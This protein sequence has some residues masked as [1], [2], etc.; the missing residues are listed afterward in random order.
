M[1][2]TEDRISRKLDRLPESPGVYLFRD[3]TGAILYIGKAR[4]L[5]QRVRSYFQAGRSEGL[6]G[7]SIRT[8]AADLDY[9]VT[10]NEVEALILESTLVKRRQPILNARLKD[11]KSFLHI[12][13]TVNE[14]FPRVLLTRRI[15][16]DGARYFGPYLPA[17]LARNLIKIINRHFQLRTCSIPIDGTLQRPCL[18][19]HIK[20]CLGPCVEGLCSPD[21]YRKAVEQVILLLEG[22]NHQ[23]LQRLHRSMH[24]AAKREQFE[25]AAFFRDRIQ[26]VQ[27]LVEKQK[28]ASTGGEN[29]DVFGYYREG[30][31]VALQLFT[32]R[33]GRVVGKREF[34]WE[35]LDWFDPPSFLRDAV[36]QYYLSARFVPDRILLP[37]PL[38]DQEI[39]EDWLTNMRENGRGRVR[40]ENPQR[41]K[42]LDLVMLVERNAVIAFESRFKLLVSEKRRLLED[43]QE[44]LQLT[45]IPRRI[46]AFDISNLQGDE[47]VASM[48]VCLDGVMSC[49]D[50]RRFRIQTVAGSNDF[51]SMQEVVGRRYRRVLNEQGTLPDLILVDGGKPQLNAALQALSQLG[52]GDLPVCALA[53]RQ[54]EIFLPDREEPIRLAPTAAALHLLQEIRDE[55]HRFAVTY[56]RR[57]R[58]L[59]DFTSELD[60]VPGVGPKRKRRLLQHF[61]SVDGVRRATEVELASL[62]GPRLAAELKRRLG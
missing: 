38:E 19:Y 25:A 49:R 30:S 27:E 41:G 14:P 20:R 18:E 17:S 2:Q 4:N 5:R 22:K 1:R 59:R 36:Q 56:H 23:L 44:A 39:I 26:L 43:L 34:F 60:A 54:E 50:Y 21:D 6:K 9:F 13:L 35:D 8:R 51:L 42:K 62:V 57:R 46:E 12:K 55:A 45:E 48:V 40:I 37:G 31:R 61:G 28:V 52:L 24:E 7:E 29:Y 33:G 53:K 3:E 11:D 47:S 16:N 15:R 10:D 32:L 58:S